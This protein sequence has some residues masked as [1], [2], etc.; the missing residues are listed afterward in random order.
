MVALGRVPAPVPVCL[1]VSACATWLQELG[2]AGYEERVR[3]RVTARTAHLGGYEKNKFE[4]LP[5]G[6]REA[7]ARR[8]SDYTAAWGYE[9]SE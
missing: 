6:L 8:W 4:P 2:L 5:A 7:V 9:W 3:P 1:C